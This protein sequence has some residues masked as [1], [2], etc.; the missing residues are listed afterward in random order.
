LKPEEFQGGTFSISNLGMFD[1]EEFIAVINPPQ[2][3]IL[4]VGKTT[5]QLIPVL[6]T[7]ATGL[8]SI[9]VQNR[10]KVTLSFDPR[11]ADE[12]S[13]TQ[14]LSAFAQFMNNPQTLV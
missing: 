1:I 5:K 2:A 12:S 7:D 4:A 13:V 3:G 14:F 10:M 8:D 11:V 6:K 9:T